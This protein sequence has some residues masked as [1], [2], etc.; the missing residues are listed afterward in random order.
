MELAGELQPGLPGLR[1]VEG[2]DA[3][4]ELGV[5]LVQRGQSSL[6]GGLTVGVVDHLPIA[7]HHSLPSR[8]AATWSRIASIHSVGAPD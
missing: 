1:I 7:G 5:E 3:I 6:R 2:E 8:S 4:T